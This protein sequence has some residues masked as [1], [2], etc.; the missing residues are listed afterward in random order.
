MSH[1]DPIAD[2]LTRVRNGQQAH[3]RFIVAPHSKVKAAI[4]Q[5][6][7]QEGYIDGFETI[8]KENNKKELR[9]DLKYYESRPV[10][11]KIKSVSK[12]SLRIYKPCK[13]LPSVL[14]G[15]GSL[16]VSTSQGVMTGKQ[17]RKLGIG[18]EILCEVA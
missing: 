10:I 4:V 1:Q 17:A 16:I 5:V 2:L 6:L 7:H 8:E 3:K 9:V 14:N 13:E 12:P 11:E 18:G 15:L